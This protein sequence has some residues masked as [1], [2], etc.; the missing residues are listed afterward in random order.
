[1]KVRK[2]DVKRFGDH[3]SRYMT[4]DETVTTRYPIPTLKNGFRPHKL[5]VDQRM[6]DVY[7]GGITLTF[8]TTLFWATLGAPIG[9]TMLAASFIVMGGVYYF[10]DRRARKL[11][12]KRHREFYV[13]H[14]KPVVANSVVADVVNPNAVRDITFHP[15]EV[16]DKDK[17]YDVMID[18]SEV[19]VARADIA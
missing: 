12:K 14:I 8:L 19:V 5:R 9:T 13:K 15:V 2:L 10:S 3:D 6:Y 7:L 1:M 17:V 11:T 18:K 4:L 16:Y